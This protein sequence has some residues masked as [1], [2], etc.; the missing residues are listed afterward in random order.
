M[1]SYTHQIDESSLLLPKIGAEFLELPDDPVH[2]TPGHT[3]TFDAEILPRRFA[4]PKE[5]QCNGRLV[6]PAL[7]GASDRI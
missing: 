7:R 5:L 1:E 6:K 2:V 4:R 3:E